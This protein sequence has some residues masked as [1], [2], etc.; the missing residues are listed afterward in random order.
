MPL[1]SSFRIFVRACQQWVAN[2]DSR[3]GAALAYYTLFSIAPLLVIAIHIAGFVFGQDA[4]R[5]E[6]VR[7]LSATVGKDAAEFIQSMV[8]AA[9][10]PKSG[11]WAPLAS[12]AVLIVGALSTF[13]HARGALCTI[14]KLEAPG[15]NTIL[16]IVLDYFLALVMVFCSGV[17]LLL[18]L[19]ASMIVPILRN[20]MEREFPGNGFEWQIVEFLTSVLFLTLFFTAIFRILSGQRIAWKYVLYGSAITSLLFSVGKFALGMYL[21]YTSTASMYG[22]AG[23]LVVFLIWVYYSSQ[24]LFFG[25]EL[26]QARRTRHEWMGE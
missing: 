24:I 15:G 1:V 18:S 25:A 2:Q 26:V 13:L 21:V 17:L 11:G 5:G 3:L 20:L 23:S 8:E 6:V 9:A 4:A 22:A 16:G 12:L 10:A 7:Q 14:W 19:A